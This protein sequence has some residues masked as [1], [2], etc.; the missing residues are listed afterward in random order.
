MYKKKREWQQLVLCVLDAV[1]IVACFYLS[2]YLTYLAKGMT[3]SFR[4]HATIAMLL[5]LCHMAAFYITDLFGDIFKRGEFKELT[6]VAFHN[7]AVSAVMLVCAYLVHMPVGLPRSTGVFYYILVVLAMSLLH[8]FY[9]KAAVRSHQ[10][11]DDVNKMYVITTSDRVDMVLTRLAEDW[12]F[13]VCAIALIDAPLEPGRTIQ[14]I[15]VVADNH[16]LIDYALHSPVDDVFL[17]IPYIN[18]ISFQKTV[19]EF[20]N[21]GISV[22]ININIFDMNVGDNKLVSR[23][24]DFNAVTFTSKL[25]DYRL[26]LIKRAMDIFIALIGLLITGVVTVFLAPVLLMESPGPLIFCQKRVG[27]NGR[28]FKFYKF[29]SMYRDA[30]E[31]KKELMEKNEMDGLMFKMTD[32]PRITK[33]GKF[34]RKTSIDELPQFWNVLRGD[35]SVVGTRPPTLD[36]YEKY[37]GYQKRRL[38]IK[39]GITGMWQ[40]SGR[41]NI[42]DFDEVVKLD[43]EYIDNWSPLLD[44]KIILQ[45]IWVVLF[46]I[47]SK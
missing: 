17:H 14:G 42:T 43:F 16:N 34:I 41:S 7:G 2:V 5:V 8:M 39:P 12:R 4:A 21:M 37:E 36:E 15:P 10:Y 44:I 45:T 3:P 31:R 32:D 29:R 1:C 9:K 18:N 38:S 13:Q 25:F 11:N 26:V 35:M 47:G 23:V 28:I 27:K 6:L 19:L 30:E 24:G 22:H 33:V 46:H 20:E 40:V